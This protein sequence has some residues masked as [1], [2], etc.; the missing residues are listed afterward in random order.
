MA[1]ARRVLRRILNATLMAAGVVLLRLPRLALRVLLRL[2][3]KL[4]VT[5]LRIL[6]LAGIVAVCHLVPP[7]AMQQMPGL[8]NERRTEPKKVYRCDMSDASL[9]LECY[10]ELNFGGPTMPQVLA[11]LS[12][13]A[14]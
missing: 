9:F 11:R 2:R 7:S 3:R 4:S 5:L 14:L 8:W 1:A 6:R 12:A 13:E 10:E